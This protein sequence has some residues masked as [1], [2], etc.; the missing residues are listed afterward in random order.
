MDQNS[1][2]LN[3]DGKIDPFKWPGGSKNLDYFQSAADTQIVGRAIAYMFN[4][5]RMNGFRNRSLK[6]FKMGQSL[7]DSKWTDL[8]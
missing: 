1:G 2:Y 4:Y 7:S 8:L 5:L 3:I 6:Q